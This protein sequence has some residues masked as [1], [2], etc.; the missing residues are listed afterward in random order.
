M[1][2]LFFVIGPL[3]LQSRTLDFLFFALSTAACL[4]LWYFSSSGY[5]GFQT[6]SHTLHSEKDGFD[7]MF[8]VVCTVATVAF[9]LGGL[10]VAS[11]P[12]T[13]PSPSRSLPPAFS[14]FSGGGNRGGGVIRFVL[15][16]VA[17]G[18]GGSVGRIF[19]IRR[20][21]VAACDTS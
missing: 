13:P 5:S 16:L 2:S 7:D 17:Y 19:K 20:R 6:V 9:A 15:L 10:L 8:S 18:D 21:F 3:D 1:P 12:S 11:S 4:F 14:L